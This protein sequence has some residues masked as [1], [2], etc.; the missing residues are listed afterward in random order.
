M[1]C[2][3]SRE[4]NNK[5]T[6]TQFQVWE[7]KKNWAAIPAG[8]YIQFFHIPMRPP[9]TPIPFLWTQRSCQKNCSTLYQAIQELK[10]THR[11]K[12]SGYKFPLDS[13]LLILVLSITFL[14]FLLSS[15]PPQKSL[16][17][18]TYSTF[19]R[20][21]TA[22]FFFLLDYDTHMVPNRTVREAIR[23]CRCWVSLVAQ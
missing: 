16:I 4:T 15:C 18:I 3:V 14:H 19:T 5:I 13:S 22:L 11:G 6:S 21:S 8:Y 9:W 12:H 1:L 2:Q 17:W 20:S 10:N 7:N 23:K